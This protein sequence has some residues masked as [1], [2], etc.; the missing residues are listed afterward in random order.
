[1]YN[2]DMS[3][4]YAQQQKIKSLEEL[5]ALTEA[6]PVNNPYEA[7]VRLKTLKRLKN[8][9]NVMRHRAGLSGKRGRVSLREAARQERI[10]AL[11]EQYREQSNPNEKGGG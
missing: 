1:M 6:S 5:I 11:V 8:R 2:G 9:L 3:D 4:Y 7:L 10:R